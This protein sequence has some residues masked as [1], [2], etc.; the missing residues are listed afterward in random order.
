MRTDSGDGQLSASC[1]HYLANRQVII[2]A[3]IFISY[4]HKDEPLRAELEKHL[5]L[6]K[7]QG[8]LDIWTDHRIL[9]GSELNSEINAG[10]ESADIIMLL[11]SSD[12]L[13]S[14]YCFSV[15]MKRAMDRQQKRTAVVVPVILRAC[16]WHSAPFGGLKALPTDGRP[17]MKWPS[18]DDAL[19]DVV[20]HLRKLLTTTRSMPPRLP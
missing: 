10:L 9:P 2:L 19:L 4:S 8:E 20:Q 17:V 3:R 15:E 7:R 5:A 16:D 12:F 18:Q 11:V 14:D 6:L 1:L 13:A